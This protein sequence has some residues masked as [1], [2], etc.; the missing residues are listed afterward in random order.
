[1]TVKCSRRL[2]NHFRREAKRAFPK[3]AFAVLIGT[4]RGDVVEV[5]QIY[6]PDHQRDAATPHK[7]TVSNSWVDQAR[8][9]AKLSGEIVLGDIHSHTPTC[10][11]SRWRE[12]GAPSQGD[13]KVAT[14]YIHAICTVYKYTSGRMVSRVS[15]WPSNLALKTCV[16][17]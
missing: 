8:S 2:L 7:I 17:E 16:T 9:L 3:E 14:D 6:I 1:M 10:A 13:W 12:D 15:F 11:R 4:V 5:T